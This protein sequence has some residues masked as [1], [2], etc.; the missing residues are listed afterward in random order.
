MNHTLAAGDTLQVMTAQTG[1]TTDDRVI[2]IAAKLIEVLRLFLA[3]RH[4]LY[5]ELL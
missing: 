1:G 5:L 4:P 2:F 3:E